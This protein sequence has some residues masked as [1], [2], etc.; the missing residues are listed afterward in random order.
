MLLLPERPMGEAWETLKKNKM[1]GG[2]FWTMLVGKS[3]DIVQKSTGTWFM[4][5]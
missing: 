5:S 2:T 4:E 3:D 1:G